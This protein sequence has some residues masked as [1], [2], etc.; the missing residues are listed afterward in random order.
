MASPKPVIIAPYDL[1]WPGQFSELRQALRV[2]LDELALAVEHVGSTAVPG[3]PAKPILDLDVVI[4]SLEL[5]PLV[6]QR[7][8]GLGYVHRGD[9]GVPGREAFARSDEMTPKDGR[10]G[11]WP[12]HHLYACAR[13]SLELARHLAFRDY[14]RASPEAAWAYA[15][16]KQHLAQRYRNDREAYTAGKTA[17][18]EEALRKTMGP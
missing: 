18:V 1:A 3:L 14:L 13:D 4:P 2:A 12:E 9:L 16:L 7:L 15:V 17:F 11:V 6:I 8:F 10:H 5:L